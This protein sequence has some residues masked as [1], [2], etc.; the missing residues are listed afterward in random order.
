MQIAAPAVALHRKYPPIDDEDFAGV[1][2]AP[3]D[4]YY[5]SEDIDWPDIP[6]SSGR[7]SVSQFGVVKHRSHLHPVATTTET[8][9]C[10]VYRGS[11]DSMV[12]RI[13]GSLIQYIRR[14]PSQLHPL[15]LKP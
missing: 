1:W 5:L 4:P 6:T 10:L 15:A 2:G 8:T 9:T 12:C 3:V 14:C 11:F 7:N 13:R